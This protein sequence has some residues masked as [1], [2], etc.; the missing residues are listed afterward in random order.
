MAI[1]PQGG[2]RAD[3]RDLETTPESEQHVGHRHTHVLEN[4]LRGGVMVVV[5]M[6]MVMVLGV[7][8]MV[9]EVM[10]VLMVVVMVVMVLGVMVIWRRRW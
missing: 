1:S 3:L 6:V 8:V 9:L 10:V 4:H 2:H 5:V 7:M